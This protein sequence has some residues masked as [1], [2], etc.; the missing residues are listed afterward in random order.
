MHMPRSKDIYTE[1]YE[2]HN[3]FREE[4]VHLTLFMPLYADTIPAIHML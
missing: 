2:V 4:E 1:V 3:Q